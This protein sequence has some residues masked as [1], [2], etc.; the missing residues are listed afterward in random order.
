MFF[1]AAGRRFAARSRTLRIAPRSIALDEA[2]R[3]DDTPFPLGRWMPGV[4]LTT[5]TRAVRLYP[6]SC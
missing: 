6:A 2:S 5:S 4:S 3:A 1:D